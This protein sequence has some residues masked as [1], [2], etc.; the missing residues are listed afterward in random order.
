[1]AN[2]GASVVMVG[3][4]GYFLIQGVR[5]PLGGIN[6]LWPLF[7]IA[8]QLLAAIA[9]CLATTVVLKMQLAPRATAQAEPVKI[10]KPA[11]ALIVFIPLVWLL[12]VTMTAGWQKIYSP[13]PR[14]GFLAAARFE[15][16]RAEMR[17]SEIVKILDNTQNPQ[18]VK[19][20][21]E[22]LGGLQ[23]RRAR[24]QFNDRLDAAVAALFMLLVAIISVIS[25]WEWYGLLRGKNVKLHESEAVW[26]PEYE[27]ADRPA[28]VLGLVALGCALAKEL[29]GE[30][31]LERAQQL[32]LNCPCAELKVDL[33]GERKADCGKSPEELYVEMTEK[34]FDGINRCC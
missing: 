2:A 34:R 30:A 29:S 11:F 28:N 13:D 26:L 32:A 16:F 15:T 19:G 7:G 9:L 25:V 23:I 12:I 1:V 4:W 31:H 17:A 24:L 22:E 3:C 10:G 20:L 5:D 14:I 27:L 21:V 18:S 6:S 8:N 33:L